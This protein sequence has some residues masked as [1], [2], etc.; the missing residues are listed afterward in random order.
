MQLPPI[1]A[2]PCKRYTCSAA[3]LL[4]HCRLR[5]FLGSTGQRSAAAVLCCA[6]QPVQEYEANEPGQLASSLR[7][8]LDMLKARAALTPE[9]HAL[10]EEMLAHAGP[11]HQVHSFWHLC[12]SFPCPGG[13]VVWKGLWGNYEAFRGLSLGDFVGLAGRRSA[14]RLP[15]QVCAALQ[16]LRLPGPLPAVCQVPEGPLLR[17]GLPVA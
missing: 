3:C 1:A 9:Q 13:G 2:L 8:V 7:M 11:D 17:P 14:A 16:L 5:S 12:P 10:L 4:S 6:A 15:R